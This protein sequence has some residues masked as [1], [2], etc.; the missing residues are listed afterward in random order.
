MIGCLCTF[1]AKI[2]LQCLALRKDPHLLRTNVVNVT[3]SHPIG[4]ASLPFPCGLRMEAGGGCETFVRIHGLRGLY[5]FVLQKV[6][7]I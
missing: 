1:S 3:D 2:M 7:Q 5:D 6:I 4:L